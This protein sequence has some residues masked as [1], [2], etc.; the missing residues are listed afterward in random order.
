[1]SNA[2]KTAVLLVNLGSPDSPNPSDVASYLTEFLNDPRVNDINWIGRKILVNGI[3]V[4]FR[5]RKKNY[6]RPKDH[7][8]S[9]TANKRKQN[10]KSVL[11]ETT[12][13]LGYSW[14]CATKIHR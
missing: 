11:V 7:L 2:R 6:G 13:T 3:I 12:A 1:M 14:P 10:F 8:S 5:H 9:I 4:P